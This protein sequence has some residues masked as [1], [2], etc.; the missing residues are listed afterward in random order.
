[1]T[2]N[3]KE[4]NGIENMDEIFCDIKIDVRTSL[5]N[6]YGSKSV[7]HIGYLTTFALGIL[8]IQI[9]GVF[10]II[11]KI[12]IVVFINFIIY[13]IGRAYYWSLFSTV[14]FWIVGYSEKY[15][16]ENVLEKSKEKEILRY[17]E[18]QGLQ[19]SMI[20]YFLRKRIYEK[21]PKTLKNYIVIFYKTWYRMLLFL[22]SPISVGIL[23][24]L[25]LL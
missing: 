7:S 8:G 23:F 22:L 9:S 24:Y 5:I 6:Y 20:D 21:Y 18:V 17:N 14:V 16:K 25:K 10:N 12:L 4:K 11:T 3:K 19:V 13:F 2:S 1:M 15:Y